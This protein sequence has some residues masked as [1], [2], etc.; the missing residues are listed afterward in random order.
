[1]SIVLS[2][3]IWRDLPDDINSVP[4]SGQSGPA[5][6]WWQQRTY[7][8]GTGR[9]TM[10]LRSLYAIIILF[11]YDGSM[12]TLE[13][14][15]RV[16]WLRLFPRTPTIPWNVIAVDRKPIRYSWLQCCLL[17]QKRY[18][19]SVIFGCCQILTAR[20]DTN[21]WYRKDS[22]M[23]RFF[24]TVCKR[25]KRVRNYPASVENKYATQPGERI[26]ICSR[27]SD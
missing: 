15:G 25:V 26:G 3:C 12:I 24:C 21:S 23:K 6:N 20:L 1:M 8:D 11:Q 7:A 2:I 17:A 5:R 13:P 18:A 19:R 27:H 10:S 22:P 9:D 14:K 16:K 4:E